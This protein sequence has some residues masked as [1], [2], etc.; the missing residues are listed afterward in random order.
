MSFVDS[1]DQQAIHT[2][3]ITTHN[4]DDQRAFSDA[5]KKIN[6]GSRV[7]LQNNSTELFSMLEFL[8]PDILF[9]GMD[10]FGKSCLECILQIR[11]DPKLADMPVVV[12]DDNARASNV[13]AAYEMGADLFMVKPDNEHRF[14]TSL[15]VLLHLDWTAPAGIKNMFRTADKLAVFGAGIR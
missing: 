13:E 3:F 7:G 9:L 10:L 4:Q 11:K 1:K 2:I 14:I 8:K 15:G 12:F 6:P 5:L